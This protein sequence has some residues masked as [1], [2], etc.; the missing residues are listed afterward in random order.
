MSWS[1]SHTSSARLHNENKQCPFSPYHELAN[2]DQKADVPLAELLVVLEVEEK[3][4]EEEEGHFAEARDY[5]V[6]L[7][8][9]GAE[10]GQLQEQLQDEVQ[11]DWIEDW[12]MED[13]LEDWLED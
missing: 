10:V 1:I 2:Y 4:E 8:Q 9:E 11:E 3:E 7:S 6:G 5:Q 13:E 12:L